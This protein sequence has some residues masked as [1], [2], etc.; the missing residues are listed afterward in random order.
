MMGWQWLQLDHMQITC[1]SLHTDNHI[2]TSPLSFYG[3]HAFLLPNQQCQGT[4][5]TGTVCQ[6][7]PPVVTNLGIKTFRILLNTIPPC[8]HCHRHHH[9]YYY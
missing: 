6:F 7:Y 8:L 2:S 4:E 5:S 9:H 1:T 3:P